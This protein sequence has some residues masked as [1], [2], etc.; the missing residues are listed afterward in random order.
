MDETERFKIAT[1]SAWNQ[2]QN[3]TQLGFIT[4]GSTQLTE[5]KLIKLLELVEE[6]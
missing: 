5:A 1:E 4:I 6:D 2:I 3:S